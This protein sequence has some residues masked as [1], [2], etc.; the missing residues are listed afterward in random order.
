MFFAQCLISLGRVDPDYVMCGHRDVETS[1]VS[2]GTMFANNWVN[3]H[4][5]Y[6]KRDEDGGVSTV[7]GYRVVSTK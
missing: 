6:G 1:S 5:R 3:V 2:P 7:R 4:A